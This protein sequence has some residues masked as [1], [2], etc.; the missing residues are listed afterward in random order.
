[1]RFEIND[2]AAAD[3]LFN[4]LPRQD[5]YALWAVT[6]PANG[7]KKLSYRMKD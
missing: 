7:T 6:V 3:R 2:Y 1:V 4:R 5:G